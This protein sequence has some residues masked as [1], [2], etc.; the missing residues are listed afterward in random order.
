MDSQAWQQ[1]MSGRAESKISHCQIKR[2]PKLYLDKRENLVPID[3]R[4]LKGWVRLD[5]GAAISE[6][7]QT[8]FCAIKGQQGFKLVR[9]ADCGP[10][11]GIAETSCRTSES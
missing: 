7:E 2:R 9:G 10:T 4:F 6:H 11:V 8:H 1:R 3:I 5:I